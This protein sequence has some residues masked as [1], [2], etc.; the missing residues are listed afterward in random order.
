MNSLLICWGVWQHTPLRLYRIFTC[1][2]RSLQG[3]PEAPTPEFNS[4][5]LIGTSSILRSGRSQAGPGTATIGSVAVKSH[6]PD[7]TSAFCLAIA[8]TGLAEVDPLLC[9]DGSQADQPIA[10]RW[11]SMWIG[12]EAGP[13]DFRAKHLQ[14]F[15]NPKLRGVPTGADRTPKKITFFNTFRRLRRISAGCRFGAD[16]QSA[17]SLA[18]M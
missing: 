11:L 12:A 4:S 1:F 3:L 2:R 14:L 7:Q 15:W 9:L 6:Q 18:L 8:R 5:R 10:S 13:H 16:P 17:L